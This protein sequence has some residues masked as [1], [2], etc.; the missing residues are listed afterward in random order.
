MAVVGL[1]PQN[2][3]APDN[4]AVNEDIDVPRQN[5][6]SAAAIG[7]KLLRSTKVAEISL[8]DLGD[9]EACAEGCNLSLFSFDW[10]KAEKKRKKIPNVNL[11]RYR[12]AQNSPPFC[13]KAIKQAFNGSTMLGQI[14]YDIS[15][16]CASYLHSRRVHE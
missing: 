16:V 1:G 10:L 4:D 2:K 13:L 6:R 5:V 12:V 11:L 7:T 3:G 14:T 15:C 8:D 9:V